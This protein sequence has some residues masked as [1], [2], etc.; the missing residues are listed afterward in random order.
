MSCYVYSKSPS[1]RLGCR[2]KLQRRRL[3]RWEWE[4]RASRVGFRRP[5]GG[6]V[7]GL[8]DILAGD[9]HGTSR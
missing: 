1:W 4:G 5:L 3:A 7:T 6:D 9:I 8:G 2:V